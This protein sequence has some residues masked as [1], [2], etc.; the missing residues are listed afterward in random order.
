MNEKNS[1]NQIDDC[2]C[3]RC[4]NQ[5]RYRSMAA[6]ASLLALLGLILGTFG[7]YDRIG[8]DDTQFQTICDMLLAALVAFGILNNPT[9]K[10][11]F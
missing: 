5:P 9:D 11:S 1:T 4:T 6:W 3:D 8:I 10:A 7:I 2:A